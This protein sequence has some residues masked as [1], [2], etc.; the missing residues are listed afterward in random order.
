MTQWHSY[1][2]GQVLS[3]LETSLHQGLTEARARQRLAQYGPNTLERQKKDSLA[4]RFFSQM[5]DPMILV[6]LGAAVLS[7]A[8]SG[9]QDWMDAGIILLIVA[10]NAVISIVQEGRAERSLEALRRMAAPTAQV[11]RSGAPD[12]RRAEELVPGDIVLLEAGDLVPADG[13]LLRC[14]GLKTDESA[15]TGESAPVAKRADVAL[16]P[17]TPLGD[18][19]NLVLAGTVVTAGRGVCAVTAT[20]MHTEMGRIAGLLSAAEQTEMP[21]QRRMVEVSKTLSLLCLL[22]CAVTFGVGLLRGR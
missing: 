17:D 1:D 11:I 19:V 7:L 12:R 10:A 16:P 21:L 18:R 2:G 20:G 3:Q 13:Y 6:L 8:A 14:T 4:R 5:K 15:M 22:V 9:F